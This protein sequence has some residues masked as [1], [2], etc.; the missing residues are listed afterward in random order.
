MQAGLKHLFVH[1]NADNMPAQELYK[2]TGFKVRELDI[3][4]D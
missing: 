3:Y 2:K 1:V 4:N